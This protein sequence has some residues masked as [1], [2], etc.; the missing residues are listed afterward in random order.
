MSGSIIQ[1]PNLN[2]MISIAID[3]VWTYAK[4]PFVTISHLPNYVKYTGYFIFLAFGILF[5]IIL[6][7]HRNYWLEVEF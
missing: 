4:I 7:K 6:W 1:I 3:F 5:F 2:K